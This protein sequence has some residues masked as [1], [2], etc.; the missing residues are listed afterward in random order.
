[1]RRDAF[2]LPQTRSQVDRRLATAE[3]SWIEASEGVKQ[4]LRAHPQ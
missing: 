1:M 2:L 4:I 3:Q